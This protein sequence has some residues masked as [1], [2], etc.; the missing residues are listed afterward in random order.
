MRFDTRAALVLG[1]L[2][3]GCAAEPPDL[4]RARLASRECSSPL[5]A[6]DDENP[7]TVDRCDMAMGMCVHTPERAGGCCLVP[8]DC[9]SVP[10]TRPRCEDNVCSY[11]AIVRCD[12]GLRPDAAARPDAGPPGRD[13]AADP[14]G[15]ARRDAAASSDAAAGAAD[16]RPRDA[17]GPDGA[18]ADAA[19]TT[20]RVR[21]GA[22]RAAPSGD[23]PGAGLLL[24]GLAGLLRRRRRGRRAGPALAAALVLS[25]APTARAQGVR[26]GAAPLPALP[27]DLLAL[28]RAAPEP[29]ALA[30]G[31]R[32]AVGYA[33]DPLVAVTTVER[34]IVA[35]RL[36]LGATA[37]LAAW[38]RLHVAAGGSM[39]LQ[40]GLGA[41]AVVPGDQRLESPAAGDPVVDARVILL[42]R[43]E[44]LELALAAT[45]RLPVGSTAGFAADDATSF[46]PRVLLG[47]ALDGRGSYLGL[48][49]GVD[50]RAERSFGD[51]TV[52]PALTWAL[53]AAGAL[54]EHAAATVELAGSTVF[55]RAFDGPHTPLEGTVG[56][57]WRQRPL[58]V[59]VGVGVGLSPGFG[60]PDARARLTV[61]SWIPI[62]DEG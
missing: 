37:S 10:C 34:P 42:D 25:L 30:V 48:S 35:E 45:L 62:L 57:R 60:T 33:D 6:C 27:D 5:D 23:A 8:A 4:G 7:C 51:L 3:C 36:T 16:A 17:G 2:L 19:Q 38:G 1:S 9:M 41:G 39:H 40:S 46:A 31:L 32:A 28:E 14:D 24:L 53:G 54:G 43:D 12:A 47:R 21:G 11:T 22:C 44:P 13:A 29:S 50:L 18:P 49:L 15:G 26:L 61:A 52:G 20:A 58:V 59:G 55:A 56:L